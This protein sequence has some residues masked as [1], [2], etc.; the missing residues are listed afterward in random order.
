[1]TEYRTVAARKA[2]DETEMFKLAENEVERNVEFHL[3]VSAAPARV[4]PNE[5][6]MIGDS[7]DKPIPVIADIEGSY[8]VCT[9][10]FLYSF[11][12]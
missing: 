9:I 11:S 1:L 10:R 6:E 7:Q 12:R 5:S 2:R 8:L 3:R 4:V